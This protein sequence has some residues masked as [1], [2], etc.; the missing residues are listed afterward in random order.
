MKLRGEPGSP[1]RVLHASMYVLG[2]LLLLYTFAIMWEQTPGAQA[3][4]VGTT[5]APTTLTTTLPPTTT[6]PS[7]TQTTDPP[8]TYTTR[9]PTTVPSGPP[10]T[11]YMIPG[12]TT[13]PKSGGSN[14]P[15]VASGNCYDPPGVTEVTWKCNGATFIC[16]N[17]ETTSGTYCIDP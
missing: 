9:P 11:T 17:K 16:H 6:R 8:T 10:S 5:G 1:T 7:T 14:P 13:V 15:N 3:Q 2:P 12:I 4:V